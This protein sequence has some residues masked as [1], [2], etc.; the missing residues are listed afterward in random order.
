MLRLYESVVCEQC[1][2]G[3]SEDE[4]VCLPQDELAQARQQV[5]QLQAEIVL[6]KEMKDQ[7]TADLRV[8]R[9]GDPLAVLRSSVLCLE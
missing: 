7:L 4:L 8:R 1:R 6:H 9:W 2:S 5:S 3:C